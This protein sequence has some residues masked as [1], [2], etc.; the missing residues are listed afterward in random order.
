MERITAREWPVEQHPQMALGVYPNP[1]N[2]LVNVLCDVPVSVSTASLSV[3]DASGRIV[4][5][6]ALRSGVGYLQMS[7]ESWAPG[8]YSLQLLCN[9][10]LVENV[11]LVVTGQ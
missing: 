8:V 4:R 6:L 3:H 9:G 11:S 1:S 2:G 7:T 10:A 5:Q